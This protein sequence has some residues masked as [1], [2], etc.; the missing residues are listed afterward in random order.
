VATVP[1]PITWVTGTVVTAA[2]L[3]TNI[4]DG[5]NFFVLPPICVLRQT[6]VQSIPNGTWTGLNMDVEDIDRDNGHS[7]VTNTSRYTAQ[8]SGWY[9][10]EGT[11]AYAGGGGSAGY[12]LAGLRIN[13]AVTP[14]AVNGWATT[15]GCS[16][17]TAAKA[18]LNVGDYLELAVQ[19]FSGVSINTD[20]TS[21][22]NCRYSL[23]WISS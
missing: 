3:N 2:Q 18:F 17:G 1:A 15:L 16:T 8:T 21:Y 22:G 19:Q 7:T 5:L 20:D 12:R 11:Y 6:I 14:F 10:A 23:K 9:Q 13:G 4:R